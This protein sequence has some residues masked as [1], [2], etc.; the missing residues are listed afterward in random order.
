MIKI[1]NLNKKFGTTIALQD[2][3]LQIARGSVC[4]VIGKSGAGKSTLIRCINLL[5]TPNSGSIKIDNVELTT[6]STKQLRQQRRQIGMIFQHFNLLSSKTVYDNIA[7][8][9]KLAGKSKQEIVDTIAP[10]LE[11]TGLTDKEQQYPSQ[12]SGGQK[13]RVAIARALVNKP[14]ILLC[15]EATSAL[16]PKTT[17]SILTLLKDINRQ[18]GLTILLITHEMQVVK[19]ICSQVAVLDHGA[20][21][22]QGSTLE[23]FTQPKTDITK[24][25]IRSTL[26]LDLPEEIEQRLHI[27]HSPGKI[28][29]LRLRFIGKSTTEP[30][31]SQLVSRYQIHF[32]ILQANI[33]LVQEQT[34]GI[35]VVEA[36]GEQSQIDAGIDYLVQQGLQVEVIGYVASND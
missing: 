5:E 21:V 16:D 35:M 8:P 20:I 23:L 19:E 33:D 4:G 29:V 2:I 31:L 30:L 1:S 27:E 6:L 32:N 3:N 13:Q 24:E 7:L 36:F 18:L 14:K 12:L 11:L 17:K 22:E 10:L 9:L 25:L 15:D 34:I 26:K 28:P